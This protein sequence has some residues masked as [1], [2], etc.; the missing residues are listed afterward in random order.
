VLKW[1]EL[2]TESRLCV[3]DEANSVFKNEPSPVNV[4]MVCG[5]LRTGKS[6]LMNCLLGSSC[7]PVSSQARSFTVGVDLCSRLFEPDELG[8]AKG[9]PRVAFVDLE[10]QGDKGISQ[11]LKVATPVLIVSKVVILVKVCPTGPSVEAI[12]ESLKLLMMAGNT[13]QTRK[14]RKG[15]FGHLHIV[16]RD[17]PQ[18]E[19]ECDDI[20]FGSE[21][22]N[23]AETDEHAQAIQLRNNVRKSIKLSF[24][25]KPKVWCLP[26][27]A[28]DVAPDDY[29]NASR[30]GFAE[31]IDEIRAHMA[32]QLAAPKLLNNMPLTGGV[33]GSLM[34]ELAEEMRSDAPS[35]NPPN[36][37]VRVAMME[38]QR[39]MEELLQ[40]ARKEVEELDSR[41]PMKREELDKDLK[42]RQEKKQEEFLYRLT[43]FFPADDMTEEAEKAKAEFKSK[44]AELLRNSEFKNKDLLLQRAEQIQNEELTKAE[45]LVGAIC[46]PL[47]SKDL[48]HKLGVVKTE[49][50]DALDSSMEILTPKLIE[51]T[52]RG[53]CGRINDLIEDKRM[54]NQLE[55]R[56][57]CT[58]LAKLSI[59]PL[60]T[61]LVALFA[62]IMAGEPAE[63]ERLVISGGNAWTN[64]RCWRHL[65]EVQRK[66]KEKE[67]EKEAAEAARRAE[68]AEE[69]EEEE[70][71]QSEKKSE[72]IR[73]ARHAQFQ[74]AQIDIDG[75]A[76]GGYAVALLT[77][78]LLARRMFLP[79]GPY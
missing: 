69:E 49:V 51:L 67:A 17:C 16:L 33:I 22:E 14:D 42:E 63:C 55:N 36:L 78:L 52:R 21:E 5:E 40:K 8:G 25:A 59:V 11:D 75:W 37:M 27:L 71:Q 70:R 23:E 38:V 76:V 77:P 44:V 48:E 45:K 43:P 39:I 20:I 18:D 72:E 50:L 61:L 34:P 6:Y 12:L 41:L 58:R 46:L 68:E 79:M 35:L 1:L 13:V 32:H 73:M 4:A 19:A 66:A 7:F 65:P 2:K 64:P 31:K 28:E 15:L 56:K 26:K 30:K 74:E 24:E 47:A 10:G 3:G 9:G 54:A 62:I 60:L 29:R 53:V 57:R